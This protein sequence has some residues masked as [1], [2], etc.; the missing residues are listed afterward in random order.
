MFQW[1]NHFGS[2]MMAL[3]NGTAAMDLAISNYISTVRSTKTAKGFGS[4]YAAVGSKS[5][6]RTE[7]PQAARV[8]L[9]LH[10]KYNATFVDS[11]GSGLDWLV[12]LLFQDLLDW[13]NWFMQ[14]RT[15]HAY[16]YPT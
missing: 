3:D 14:A 13:S 4:N 2:L 16:G 6:D 7:P 1:D 11:Y 9:T 5:V 15:H 12:E 10:K 8:L